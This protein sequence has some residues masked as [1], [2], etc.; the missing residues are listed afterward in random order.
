ERQRER[1]RSYTAF[2]STEW[3]LRTVLDK[4]KISLKPTKFVRDALKTQCQIKAVYRSKG[5]FDTNEAHVFVALD[6]T[7]FYAESGGQIGDWGRLYN[8]NYEILVRSIFVHRDVYF[9]EGL[10]KRGIFEDI[11]PDM[12]VTAE[13]DADRRWDIMRNHTATH[14]THAALRQVLGPHIK[15]SG[16]YVGPDRLRFDFSHHQPMTA[17]EIEQVERLVNEQILQGAAVQTDIM[18][19]DSARKSGAMA[20][21]GEKYEDHVR[22]VSV[23]DF[24]KELCGGTHVEN[25]SQIGPLFITLE[26]GIASGVR[27]LEAITGHEA[28]K[29]MLEAKRFRQDVATIVGRPETDAL[30]GVQQLRDG[31]ATLQKELKK[32]KAEMFAGAGR[33]I[34]EETTVGGLRVITN[35]FDETDRD[36]MAGWMDTQKARNEAVV[37]FGMGRINGKV[38]VMVSASH[39]AVTELQV[40]AGRLSKELLPKFG[41]RGGGKASFAQGTVSEDISPQELFEAAKKL[42]TKGAGHG[43]P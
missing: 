33:P 30:E 16:S 23:A 5:V 1:S 20:L 34:G 15:Q 19:I 21:F 18:D 2:E 43:N 3:S 8:D 6:Q 10:L 35:N 14:L 39:R 32:V 42:L 24:S 17:K 40:D 37:A 22:V 27:R 12:L 11:P 28:V 31:H 25:V 9:H 36:I 4:E 38:T 26:T 41:G 13:V 7:P 29:F